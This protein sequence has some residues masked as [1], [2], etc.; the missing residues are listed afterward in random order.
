MGGRGA[1]NVFF[2]GGGSAK[3]QLIVAFSHCFTAPSGLTST[4]RENN[5]CVRL[6]AVMMKGLQVKG[7]HQRIVYD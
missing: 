2:S 6:A 3:L 4:T 5:V 7:F 1:E